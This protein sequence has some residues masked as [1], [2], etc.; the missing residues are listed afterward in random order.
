MS[1]KIREKGKRDGTVI[2]KI[3]TPESFIV[4]RQKNNS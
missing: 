2:L 3:A 4:Q 1:G